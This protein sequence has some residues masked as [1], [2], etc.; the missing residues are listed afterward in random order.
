MHKRGN[1]NFLNWAGAAHSASSLPSYEETVFPVNASASVVRTT[2]NS[3]THTDEMATSLI[4][5]NGAHADPTNAPNK[6]SRPHS[7]D[8]STHPPRSSSVGSSKVEGRGD[9]VKQFVD[10]RRSK[11]RQ[12]VAEL[13][14]KYRMIYFGINFLLNLLFQRYLF[15]AL[16]KVQKV[17]FTC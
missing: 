2:K 10:N 14:I 4:S 6:Y 12:Y 3:R 9:V 7:T 17:S 16:L 13:S 5:S 1:Q 15:V 8:P 11:I